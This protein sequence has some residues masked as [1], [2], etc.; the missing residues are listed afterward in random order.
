MKF[1]LVT[2]LGLALSVAAA[3]LA[4]PLAPSDVSSL[5]VREPTKSK[6]WDLK[7]IKDSGNKD[8][9][10]GAAGIGGLVGAVT[11]G[12][13]SNSNFG[14]VTGGVGNGAGAGAGAGAGSNDGNGYAISYFHSSQQFANSV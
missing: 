2:I 12:L 11:G 13:G 8:G 4:A 10:Q 7:T 6:D 5:E 14:S 9:N 3:P 1:S